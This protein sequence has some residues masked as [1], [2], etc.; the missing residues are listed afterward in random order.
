MRHEVQVQLIKQLETH[1]DA[2]T[3]VDGGGL[4]LNPTQV[5]IDPE[6]AER[7]WHEFFVGHPQVIGLTGDLPASGSFMTVDDLGVPILATR[8]QEGQVRAFVNSCR[9]RGS[10]LETQERGEA[11]N[12]S[13]PFHNWTYG[14]DGTLLGLTKPDHFGD[15]DTSCLGLVELPATDPTA[16]SGSIP[17]RRERSTSR[18]S[19]ATS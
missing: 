5:N 4:M 9:H 1:L 2:S 3:N 19:W 18:R 10:L 8:D 6:L 12:F 17:T 13:C 11:K 14:L 15:V 16:S 7:E